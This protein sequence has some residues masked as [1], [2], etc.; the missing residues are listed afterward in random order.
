MKKFKQF[1]LEKES[2]ISFPT[3]D[4]STSNYDLDP[5]YRNLQVSNLHGNAVGTLGSGG[6]ADYIP[7]VGNL[8]MWFQWQFRHSSG[9]NWGGFPIPTFNR[10]WHA[11]AQNWFSIPVPERYERY[12]YLVRMYLDGI[13][14]NADPLAPPWPPSIA[15]G[16]K[17]DGTPI[18]LEGECYSENT[19][20]PDMSTFNPWQN[21]CPP[22]CPT[23]DG[24]VSRDPIHSYAGGPATQG[25]MP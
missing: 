25:G 11:L 20:P 18:C 15:I 23:S 10:M 22:N 3:E 2:P 24:R 5:R 1:L 21:V 8:S 7:G 19:F 14:P 6:D 12:N 17:K 9:N 16:Y 13:G 4:S